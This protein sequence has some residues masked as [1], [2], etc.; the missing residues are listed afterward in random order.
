MHFIPFFYPLQHT[1]KVIS[2]L[3]FLFLDHRTHCILVIKQ[4]RLADIPVPNWSLSRLAT[5]HIKV[6]N[7]LNLNFIQEAAQTCGHAAERE[8][9]LSIQ[10]MMRHVPLQNSHASLWLWNCLGDVA[11]KL[12][13]YSQPSP[14]K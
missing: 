10:G 7:P 1:N 14:K 4:S 13:M 8:K 3:K 6:I 2:K 12:S 11:M 5:F 9:R